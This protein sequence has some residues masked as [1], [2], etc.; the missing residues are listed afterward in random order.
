MNDGKVQKSVFIEDEMQRAY[1]D[2]SMSMITARA[3][4]DARDGLKPVHRRVLFSMSEQGMTYGRP[5]KKS[6][7]VVGDVIGKYHPHGDAAVYDALV[8]MAQPFSLRYPMVDGQGNF[9][10]VDGDPPA[11][12]RYTEA[13]MTRGAEEMIADLDKDTVDFVPNYDDTMREP[14]VLPAKVPFLLVN[15]ATGIAVGMAT[16]MAPHNLTEVVNAVIA[17]IDDPEIEI[18][19]LMKIIPGPDFPTGGVI[20]GRSGIRDAYMTGRGKV[21]VRAR[22]SVE[23]QE[24][25]RERIIITE[26]PYM[27]NKTV[28]LE[29]MADLVRNK[30]V[31]GIS[32]IRDESDRNG[33]RIVVG[34]K[35]D[36]YGEVVLN[37]LYRYTNLQTSFGII[38]LALVDMRPRQLNLKEMINCHIDH[39]H[40]VI[41]R[42]T[43]HDLRKARE[44][45]HIL[46]GLRIALQNIDEIIQLIKTSPS[47][48]EAH[49]RLTARFALSDIQA[50]AILD[51]RLQRLTGLERD[52]IEAEYAELM[53]Q[54]AEYEDILAHRERRMSIIKDELIDLRDRYGDER[55]TDIM[56]SSAD[57][58]IEDMIA[59][60]P[61]VIT[62][63]G[64]GYIKRSSVSVYRSQGRGGRGVRGMSS[65][66]EDFV[67]HMF[68]A[69]AHSQILFFTNTGRC[70][71]LKVYRIPEAGRQS[72]G[73]AIVNLLSMRPDE[74]V[75]G[76]VTVKEFDETH[77]IVI[78]TERGVINKQPLRAYSNIRRDGINAIHLDEGD[79]LIECKLTDGESDI[80]LGTRNGQA[81]RFH[82]SATRELGRNTRGM[83]GITLREDDRVVS[84]VVVKEEDDVLTV[85]SRGYGK[86]TPVG[87]YRRTNRGGSGIINIKLTERNG[88]VTGLKGI[89]DD[90]DLMLITRQ[91]II[92]RSDLSK[93]STISRNTQGV[94]LI[95]LD[96]QD[97]V[98]DLA[99]CEKEEE[100]L[101]GMETVGCVDVIEGEDPNGESKTDRAPEESEEE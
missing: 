33:M 1:L 85:T 47:P 67:K 82:E 6:A 66:N 21:I 93:I 7:R 37:R 73:R 15:G 38:N 45:A 98:I 13:R 97:T 31:E 28:L 69:S 35:K 16:N 56:E 77:F 99:L 87:D 86:R 10:S 88:K 2:Y 49:S 57:V 91:G 51:M 52:K 17:A 48:D 36:A 3:L 55:R 4:P 70:Y 101:E 60:E 24:N 44:R 46:E 61:M 64:N 25:G 23:E 84:M 41:T 72:G 9:G 39:R 5:T 92:I 74:H 83:K 78:A 29:R 42:R 59:D 18:A 89:S 20:Y 100:P 50:K 96:E 53:K 40:T 34:V 81:V 32:F 11:A 63:T 26:I 94:R 12:M 43:E 75:S 80:I 62:M 79:R 30:T 22:A 68:V 27:V 90:G 19:D 8:R 54:I 14:S 71:W 76:F 58:D 65:R 95:A